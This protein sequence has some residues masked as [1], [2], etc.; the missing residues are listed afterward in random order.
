MVI[1]AVFDRI[2]DVNKM[3][4]GEMTKEEFKKQIKGMYNKQ[5][6][7]TI[8]DKDGNQSFY[9]PKEPMEQSESYALFIEIEEA[10]E[11]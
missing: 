5:I 1:R 4:G 6:Y 7:F 3:I 10:E 2:V 11:I 8:T 9:K